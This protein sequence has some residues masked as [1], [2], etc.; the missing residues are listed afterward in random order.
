MLESHSRSSGGIIPKGSMLQ[1]GGT[2][3]NFEEWTGSSIQNPSIL[4]SVSLSN[5]S[6]DLHRQLQTTREQIRVMEVSHQTST[7]VLE[8]ELDHYRRAH[9]EACK[10]VVLL[11]TKITEPG[12]GKTFAGNEAGLA[13]DSYASDNSDM[14]GSSTE[15]RRQ[16]SAVKLEKHELAEALNT[17]LVEVQLH[18]HQ[19]NARCHEQSEKIRLASH[20]REMVASELEA[21]TRIVQGSKL[22]IDSV[23]EQ[24]EHSSSDIGRT[25]KLQRLLQGNRNELHSQNVRLQAT[26]QR[27]DEQSGSSSDGSPGSGPSN[28]SKKNRRS[29]SRGS[30]QDAPRNSGLYWDEPRDDSWDM[31]LKGETPGNPNS[32]S[33]GAGR[34][35]TP[36]PEPV[37]HVTSSSGHQEPE[38]ACTGCAIC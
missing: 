13:A 10:H 24:L 11:E 32:N 38:E 36:P 31:G 25:A 5:Y 2:P 16:L 35:A 34:A 18:I 37:R 9:S 1:C 23:L 22:A 20:G 15:L 28:G 3:T 4:Q 17:Q 8:S 7:H 29:R 19:L 12:Q 6:A 33:R 30:V 27:I 26:R 21:L 14:S